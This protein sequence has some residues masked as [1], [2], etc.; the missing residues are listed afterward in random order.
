[1]TTKKKALLGSGV[2]LALLFALVLPSQAAKETL[3]SIANKIKYFAANGTFPAKYV[4]YNNSKSG[5]KAKTTQ[6]AIDE[7]GVSLK[8]LVSGGGVKAA[9]DYKVAALTKTT[10]KGN[11]QGF[12]VDTQGDACTFRTSKEFTVTFTPTSETQGTFTST[13]YFPFKPFFNLTDGS[14][15]AITIAEF[16][17]ATFTGSY[18]I[19]GSAI[20][21]TTDVADTNLPGSQGYIGTQTYKAIG[22]VDIRGNTIIISGTGSAQPVMTLTRQ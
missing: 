17:R 6:A 7:L 12:W 8:K 9:G 2:A 11:A 15:T 21:A 10:W 16:E 3:T 18:W 13:Y 20:F 22:V 1:M 4:T 5:L 19:S 14:C